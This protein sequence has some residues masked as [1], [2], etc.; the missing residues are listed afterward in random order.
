M[1]YSCSAC[2]YVFPSSSLPERCPDCGRLRP[3]NASLD[4]TAW[5]EA[6][7]KEKREYQRML[8]NVR[9][10]PAAYTFA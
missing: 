8:S 1:L 2:R 5:Y 9:R 6:N 3:R 4:E 7:E 10:F